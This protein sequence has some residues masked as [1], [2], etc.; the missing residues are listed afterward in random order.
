LFPVMVFGMSDLEGGH[1]N[2]P[3]SPRHATSHARQRWLL[4]GICAALFIMSMF[5]RVSGAIIAPELSHDLSLGSRELGLVGGVFF[6]AFALVQIPLGLSLDRMGAKRTMIALNLTGVL[7]ALLFSQASGL[8]AA[9]VGRALLGIG[10][11]SNLMGSLKLFTNWFDLRRFATLSGTLLSLGTVGTLAATSPLALMVASLGW[12]N[13]FA[14]LAALH[15][16]IILALAVLIR[17][18]PL[19]NS[20]VTLR[21]PATG[22]RERSPAS[23]K[24]LTTLFR[25]PTYW[26]ISWSIFLRYGSFASIQALWAGPFLMSSLGLHPVPAGNVL[27]MISVGFIVG[28]PVGGW[29]SDRL[30]KSRKKAIIPAMTGSALAILIWSRWPEGSPVLLLGVLLF[31][32]GF[33]NSFNAISYAHIRELMPAHMAGTAMTGINV[34]TMTGAGVFIHG[35]GRAIEHL[36]SAAGPA[37]DSYRTAF[38]IASVAVALSALIYVFTRDTHPSR[39]RAGAE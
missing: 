8:Y 20:E 5:Y 19:P 21:Q 10:M 12:R 32:N 29:V 37:G 9:L 14:A 26:A 30:L 11:A 1:G 15:F 22:S 13:T 27:L 35:L 7:G 25:S 3:P 16:V 33:F 2:P 36:E 34:F 28:A 4:F 17:E 6:Y 18:R 39:I 24:A 23:V 38:L 31:I